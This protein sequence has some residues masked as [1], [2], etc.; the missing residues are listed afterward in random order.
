MWFIAQSDFPVR[1]EELIALVS[2]LGFF[3]TVTLVTL[4]LVLG[5]IYKSV[6][7]TR[8]NNELVKN[9]ADRGYSPIEIQNILVATGAASRFKKAVVVDTQQNIPNVPPQKP[10][11]RTG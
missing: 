2:V 9:M 3:G 11:A 1:E 10:I 4:T 5:S 7:I 6:R 8:L